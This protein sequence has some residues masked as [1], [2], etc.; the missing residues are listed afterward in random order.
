MNNHNRKVALAV[1]V[2][3]IS[4]AAFFSAGIVRAQCPNITVLNHTLCTVN[5]CMIDAAG[6]VFCQLIPAG[7]GPVI[8]PPFAPKAVQSAGGIFYAFNPPPPATVCTPCITMPGPGGPA[9]CAIV[10]YDPTVCQIDI[11]PCPPPCLP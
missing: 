6:T 3:M 4:L 7:G 2:A 11:N 9:C 1:A 5:L 10:C 8:I